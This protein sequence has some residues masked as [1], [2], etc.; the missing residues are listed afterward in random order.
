VAAAVR[1]WVK[2][3]EKQQQERRKRRPRWVQKLHSH[4][5]H[6]PRLLSVSSSHPDELE[7]EQAEQAVVRELLMRPAQERPLRCWL[8]R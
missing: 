3:G 5:L 7:G 1:R 4:L 8:D 6:S 2:G